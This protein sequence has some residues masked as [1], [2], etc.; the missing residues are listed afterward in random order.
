MST[1]STGSRRPAC[2][3]KPPE[4]TATGGTPTTADFQPAWLPSLSAELVLAISASS[5]RKSA[6]RARLR[7]DGLAVR[8][9]S[10]QPAV[11]VFRLPRSTTTANAATDAPTTAPMTME[12]GTAG[13]L[14]K[15]HRLLAS[16]L[17]Q[18][19]RTTELPYSSPSGP[20]THAPAA[21]DT[22]NQSLV[23]SRPTQTWVS[24]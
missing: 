22:S 13:A 17:S 10:R 9:G 24:V 3:L 23:L 4:K 18:A 11:H 21:T 15:P 12:N 14:A 8:G 5:C 20:P 16:G 19:W 6:L 2:S 1:R 7:R